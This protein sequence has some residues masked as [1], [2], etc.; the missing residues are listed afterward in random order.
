MEQDPTVALTELPVPAPRLVRV[1]RAR[2]RLQALYEPEC[3]LCE[4]R[5]RVNRRA[6]E[7][8]ECGLAAETPVYR[9]LVHLGEE[10]ALVPSYTVWL[11]GCNFLCSFCSDAHALRPPLPGRVYPAEA[12]AELIAGDLAASK[13]PVKN[14]NFVGG[15]P[16]I[17]LPY[18][19]D[20]GLAL[21][22]RLPAAPPF[23]LNTNGYLT[24]GALEAAGPSMNRRSAAQ[25][26]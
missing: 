13:R 20:V 8:G 9:R 24:M 18:L 17:S 12:L 14:I 3:L 1:E 5:C 7:R 4:V 22:R 16:S 10:L 26:K 21:L 19:C 6:G 23:L 15:E 2:Q 25:P 11:S